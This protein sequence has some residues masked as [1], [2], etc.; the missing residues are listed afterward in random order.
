MN[1]SLDIKSIILAHIIA[2]ILGAV[3]DRI[4]G[5]PMN[6]PHPIRLIGRFIGFL[7]HKLNPAQRNHENNGLE[8]K[9]HLRDAEKR[10]HSAEFSGGILLV[11]CVTFATVLITGTIMFASYFISIYLG[12]IVE[13]I[14]TCYILAAKSLKVESLKVSEALQD[15]TIEDA[16]YAVSMIVGRDTKNLDEPGVIRAAV[17]TVAENASDGVIAPLIYT[18]IGGPVLGFFYKAVNTMD[19]MVGYHNDKYEYFGKAAAKTDD[20]LNF[21]PA[22]IC[23]VLMIASTFIASVFI[24]PGIYSGKRAF[25]IFRRDRYNHKSPNSAQA[26]SVCAGALG[27]QL[28]G[29]AYYFGKLVK[30]PFI[31]DPIREIERR[32]IRRACKLMYIT[33]VLCAVMLI[34]FMAV[35]IILKVYSK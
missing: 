7:D 3:L 25:R 1:F 20:V 30:K 26:E 8:S 14:L 18:F 27:L 11:I 2:F 34:L 17:E 19:S 15:G 16:R 21:I 4:I 28:A 13:A 33:E 12:L 9:A 31:G 5:D 10:K 29:D 6:F 35:I 22:R 32:D 23:A 24:E